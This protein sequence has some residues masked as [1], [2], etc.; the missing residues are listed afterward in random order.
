ME[1]LIDRSVE[2]YL[3]RYNTLESIV[4]SGIENLISKL[5]EQSVISKWVDKL[6]KSIRNFDATK[7]SQLQEL[8]KFSKGE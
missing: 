6:S 7:F 1:N 3:N 2:S 8:L 4:A 5:P